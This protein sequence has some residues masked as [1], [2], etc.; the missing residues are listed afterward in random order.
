MQLI[1]NFRQAMFAKLFGMKAGAAT[2]RSEEDFFFNTDSLSNSNQFKNT[3]DFLDAYNFVRYFGG[4]CRIL[5]ND[6]SILDFNIM[7]Q[8][9]SG[10]VENNRPDLREL[11][12]NPNANM[13][14]S[15]FVFQNVLHLLLDGNLF[16][17]KDTR[18]N[19]DVLSIMPIIPSDVDVYDQ[20]GGIVLARHQD[21]S[22][23]IEYYQVTINDKE[24]RI[25]A[26]DGIIEHVKI[27][28][29]NNHLRGM[30]WVEQN[31]NSL[32]EDRLQSVFNSNLFHK[33]VMTKLIIKNTEPIEPIK[34]KIWEKR[35][36]REYE[37]QENWGKT[38]MLGPGQDAIPLNIDHRTMQFIE[39]RK[40]TRED[41]FGT[42]FQIPPIRVQLGNDVKYDSAA[43]QWKIYYETTLPSIYRHLEQGYTRILKHID[44]SLVFRFVPKM[45]VD[46]NQASEIASRAYNDGIITGN[47]Y[48]KRIG[49][50]QMDDVD[51]LNRF[52]ISMDKLPADFAN[53]MAEAQVQQTKPKDDDKCIEPP[54]A[55]NIDNAQSKATAAQ[56]FLD[57]KARQSK[58]RLEKKGAKEFRKFYEDMEK[59]VIGSMSKSIDKKD[60][61]FDEMFDES[62]EK[63][64]AAESSRAFFTSAI[65][66]SATDMNDVLGTSIDTSFKNA[67][68]KLLVDR[69]STK[70]ADV[71]I[72]TRKD[73][74]KKIIDEALDDG[75]GVSETQARIRDHFKTLNGEDAWRADRIARAETRN[76][77]DSMS[78]IAYQDI[79]VRHVR[80][81][82]CMD[83]GPPWDCDDNGQRA[84]H[85]VEMADALN[86]KPNHT[87]TV[88]PDM[89]DKAF[90]DFIDQKIDK[91]RRDQVF[92]K[93]KNT[94]NMS[95]SELKRWSE[96][97]C[98]RKASQDRSPIR[99]NLRLL[100]KKK[101]SWTEK[102]IKDANKTIAFVA[103][104][105]NVEDGPDVS[106]ECPYSKR[107]ISLRNWAFDPKK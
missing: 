20:D 22:T 39:Q 72:Q 74:L 43:E 94:V 90:L 76:A 17:L 47:E 14:Y 73:E 26:R 3:K 45:A 51:H 8:T 57:R 83:P 44:R 2:S 41:V 89:E 84:K 18:I 13:N 23:S 107:T 36:R 32:D 33:G 46:P 21:T 38:M 75:V 102:D 79:G 24:R 81:I 40:L 82:G 85:P 49:V 19:N 1:N 91:E 34:Q 10:L 27:I 53:T 87:G 7:K 101:E 59:R 28:G 98:S 48:R 60:I 58:N 56:W 15:E 61:N 70:Y 67:N 105:R 42:M 31:A 96:S 78:K 35:F 25:S 6:I 93:Y 103:R 63:K 50:D 69:L 54:A 29:P 65:T 86:F 55:K 9:A 77:Y 68:I 99:R 5:A 11:F 37:G 71:T 52:Y 66:I 88:V 95:H 97:K 4:A 30:G 106:K 92:R 12:E 104:M 64:I 80:V 16:L 62:E 100:S